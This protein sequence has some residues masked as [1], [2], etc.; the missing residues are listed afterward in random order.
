MKRIIVVGGG[1]A[2]FFAAVNIAE[3]IP[4]SSVVVLEKSNKLLSKVRISGGGRCN[5]TNE[6][7]LP[8]EL[9]KF[10]PRGQK[11][12][13]KS[14]SVFSTDSMKNWLKSQGVETHT[15]NDLRVFPVSNKSETIID[16]FL[17]LCKKHRVEIRTKYNVQEIRQKNGSWWINDE[18]EADKIVWATGSSEAAWKLLDR[19]D[20]SREAAVPS[21]FTFNVADAR[22]HDL[23]GL[24][25]PEVKVKIAGSK[26][27]ESGPLLVTHWGLSGPA[28]LK[29]SS[30]AAKQ[31]ADR[32][33][34]FDILV[35]FF[36][37]QTRDDLRSEL[38]DLIQNAPTKK[39]KNIKWQQLPNRYWRQLLNSLD[40]LE[41]T[42]GNMGRKHVNKILEELTQASFSVKGKSTFKEEFV[43]CGGVSLSEINLDSMESKKYPGLYLAGET[44]NIDALTGGFNFQACWTAGW[45][46]SEHIKE[47]I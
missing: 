33:Y 46:I 30:W 37:D 44:L 1:A 26:L 21:L 31:L 27:E 12:L 2:G 45:V 35:N 13:Y 25:F 16:C 47:N 24:A 40:L 38:E 34:S 22:I 11:K 14:F 9:V 41:K 32:D 28:I 4:D 15:E 18:L 17:S 42:V 36:P 8:S 29:L 20:F 7:K 6:R 5:V 3:K 19:L 39:L 43:T 10:Y 23:Q